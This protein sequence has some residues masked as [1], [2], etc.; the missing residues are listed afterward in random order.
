MT[1]FNIRERVPKLILLA[2]KAAV[3][4][5]RHARCRI[6]PLCAP[7]KVAFCISRYLCSF[8]ILATVLLSA[9]AIDHSE[10]Q[11]PSIVDTSRSP[12]AA[13]QSVD[14][15]DVKWTRGF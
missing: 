8:L 3:H 15:D 11:T 4:R 13:L 14:L 7:F 1:I 6:T 2:R 12:H 10:A 9:S 5:L